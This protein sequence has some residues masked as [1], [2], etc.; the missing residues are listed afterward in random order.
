MIPV[1][2]HTWNKGE[3]TAAPTL[4]ANGSKKYT[5]TVCG[6]AKTVVLTMAEIREAAITLTEVNSCGVKR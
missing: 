4:E 2:G 3:V 1:L 5:C 6:A